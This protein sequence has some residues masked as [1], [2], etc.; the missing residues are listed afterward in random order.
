M[1]D[2]RSSNPLT[3]FAREFDGQLWVE[4]KIAGDLAD[5]IERLTALLQIEANAA[6]TADRNRASAI[7]ENDRLR[8]AQT[9]AVRI[10]S[11][12]EFDGQAYE[13]IQRACELLAGA[14]EPNKLETVQ[15]NKLNAAFTKD[16]S[17][18]HAKQPTLSATQERK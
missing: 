7:A 17:G 13:A 11:A 1:S 10:L 12:I 2:E 3:Y 9:E 6:D 16:D 8:A 15:Q 4:A 14:A 18:A 5:E